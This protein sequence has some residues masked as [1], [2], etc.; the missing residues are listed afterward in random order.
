MRW[1]NT[2]LLKKTRLFVL[3]L[4]AGYRTREKFSRAYGKQLPNYLKNYFLP[5]MGE[6]PLDYLSQLNYVA[7]SGET[8]L[9]NCFIPENIF[10]RLAMKNLIKLEMKTLYY[11]FTDLNK[12]ELP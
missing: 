2:P 8:E 1:N 11:H 3:L 4:S 5:L 6:N 9:V 7:T 12:K 10:Y